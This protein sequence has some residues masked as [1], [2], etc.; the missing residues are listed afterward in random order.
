MPLMS[1]CARFARVDRVSRRSSSAPPRSNLRIDSSRAS[2]RVAASPRALAR[3][4]ST[5]HIARDSPRASRA[6]APRA[7]DVAPRSD[8][9]RGVTRARADAFAARSRRRR[10]RPR[11]V[12]RAASRASSRARTRA[13]RAGSRRRGATRVR[14]RGRSRAR[15]ATTSDAT[16][17]TID[18]NTQRCERRGYVP[19]M[20]GGVLGMGAKKTGERACERCNAGTKKTPG[21]I[22][23]GRC[24]GNKFLLFRSADWR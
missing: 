14:A 19:V 10:R 17:W 11:R 8:A 6:L 1:S 4:L 20:T 5:V 22:A 7:S 2:S 16:G 3:T 23:C 18:G 12:A 13:R 9:A 15:R 24:Q 21:R